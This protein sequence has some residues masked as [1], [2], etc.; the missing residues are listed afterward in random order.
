MARKYIEFR[1][2][3]YTVLLEEGK[4]KP[5]TP[6]YEKEELESEFI[7]KLNQD[8]LEIASKIEREI[9]EELYKT[10]QNPYFKLGTYLPRF[11]GLKNSLVS[12]EVHF[13]SGSVEMLAIVSVLDWMS[14]ISGSIAL[15]DMIQRIIKRIIERRVNDQLRRKSWGPPYGGIEIELVQNV[16]NLAED[17]KKIKLK[18]ENS[19]QFSLLKRY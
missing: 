15:L 14:R 5:K 13:S 2:E 11:I 19:T 16:E 17:K 10:F 7:D 8:R 6:N 9:R 1:F 18:G 3:G 12:V 4:R